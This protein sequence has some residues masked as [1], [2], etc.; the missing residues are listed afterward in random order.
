[1]LVSNGPLALNLPPCHIPANPTRSS[2]PEE[3]NADQDEMPGAGGTSGF[4]P[5]QVQIESRPGIDLER[6]F[7]H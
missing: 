2:Y 4:F 3:E 1:M 5:G 7:G 6:R